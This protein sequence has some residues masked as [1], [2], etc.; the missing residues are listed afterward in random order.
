MTAW[1]IFYQGQY[2]ARRNKKL[3][4]ILWLMN[5]LVAAVAALPMFSL[6]SREWNY[7]L[8]AGPMMDRFD[9]DYVVELIY[10]YWDSAPILLALLTG[11]GILYVTLTLLT[12]GGTLAVFSGTEKR[13]SAP[14]FFRGCGAFFWR[15][16]RLFILSVIFYGIFVF[17]VNGGLSAL[18]S[19][20]TRNWTMEK[21]VLFLSWGRL[22][23]VA[24]FFILINMIFDYAKVRIVVEEGRSAIAAGF[25]SIKFVFKNFRKTLAVYLLCF[26]LGVIVIAIYNPL[27][28][29]LPQYTRKWVIAVFILQQ[30]FI[31]ARVY[32]RLTFF[33]SEVILYEG[34]RPAPNFP[35]A[36][37]ATTVTPPPPAGNSGGAVAEP[38][39]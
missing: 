18:F 21:Y 15:F 9:I 16:L 22:L 29:V 13:F 34:L 36:V 2:V 20:M 5:A 37:M 25:R 31:L 8:A 33:S 26:L 28:S 23:L 1:E 24:F 12:A 39:L 10:K 30:L 32:V 38:V 17:G 19:R 27:E 6:L 3:W 14:V 4:F 7:S 35:P 11:L